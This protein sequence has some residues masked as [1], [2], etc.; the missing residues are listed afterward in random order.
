MWCMAPREMI[1]NQPHLL[2]KGPVNIS[3]ILLT[4]GCILHSQVL[5]SLGGGFKYYL[6]G[7]MGIFMG[8][9]S[10]RE[11]KRAISK[12]FP[13]I[14]ESHCWAVRIGFWHS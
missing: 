13:T 8:Y 9:V 2:S 4:A 6:P 3:L 5:G 7:K 11:G 14:Q 1:C 10:F 12:N